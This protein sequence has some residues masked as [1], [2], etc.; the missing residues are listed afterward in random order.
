MRVALAQFD[1]TIG[2]L[3]EASARIRDLADRAAAEKA[4]LLVLPELS[5]LGYPPRDLLRRAEVVPACEAAVARLARDLPLPTLIGS[6]R[7]VEGGSRPIANAV[8]LCRGGVV[9]AWHDKILLP[10][11][12][13][14]DESRWFE[15]GSSPL[16]FELETAS[17]PRRVGVLICEDLWRA[18]DAEAGRRYDLDPVGM[19]AKAG[20]DLVV[21]PS[22]S[23][24]VAG[25]ATRHRR[26]LA[27]VAQRLDAPVAMV[28]QTGAH[29]D[30]IF[31]GGSMIVRPDASVAG[32]L[33]RFEEAVAVFDPGDGR[34][35][36]VADHD[37]NEERFLALRRS[38]ADYCRR[39]GHPGAVLGLSGGIDSAV[40]VAL[41]VAALGPDAVL[42]LLLPS[43]HS[44][45]G[46]LIDARASAEALGIRAEEVPIEPIHAAFET[47]LDP[48][49]RLDGDGFGGL[50]DEN[51]QARSRGVLLMAVS[52]ARRR[53]L[54]ST[55]NKSELAVGYSTLYGDMCGGLA[56]IG[57]L[58]KTEV[59]AL[60]R[61]MNQHHRR[62]GFPAPP[63]PT[64]SIEKPPSAE[65]RP[66]QR[67][68][69]SLPS[70][71]VLDAYLRA[72][73]DEERGPEDIAREI[74]IDA[75]TGAHL[76][77]LLA[78][79]EFK[80]YQATIIP[81]LAPRTF[82]RGREMPVVARW[83]P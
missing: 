47:T 65:L 81:K 70:Y 79:S 67:D 66:D 73:V 37:E 1:L 75:G 7:R 12:D 10:T 11:Y 24:F 22:A 15:P 50:A 36:D 25:K 57:D 20:C 44:S 18:E 29:D 38:I 31:D 45:E 77:R 3:A 69:D 76:E 41:A 59:F 48:L 64:S 39:S 42:G 78:I 5:I 61:W 83:R 34:T 21:S 63:V 52:N 30:L 27:R 55:S 51:V 28:N 32:G 43:R 54:L 71:D 68:D 14:F 72:R 8:A 16:I 56:P 4:D 62:L 13:V 46:S 23:P 26:I 35:V 80:R 74:G 53:L 58:W 60:A 17:G 19:L 6:P 40:V 49:L 82:G 9:E 33:P 2:D